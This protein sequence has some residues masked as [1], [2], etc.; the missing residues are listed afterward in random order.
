[1]R[2]VLL[3]LCTIVSISACVNLNKPEKVAECAH[4]NTCV[5][6]PI[7]GGP[8]DVRGDADASA[9]GDGQRLD[10]RDG[11]PG[12]DGPAV[13]DDAPQVG[14][15]GPAPPLDGE[16]WL[17]DGLGPVL[18]GSSDPPPLIVGDAATDLPIG[19]GDGPPADTR[20]AALPDTRD[21]NRD[22]AAGACAPGGV[23]K[24]A[25]T[26]CRA[27]LDVCD[28]EE[29]CDG[30]SADC[31]ADQ[32]VKA[33]RE[34]RAAKGDCDIAETCTGTKA[35]CPADGFKQSG[36]VCRAAAGVCDY[37][38]VCSGT[39]ATCPDDS[40]KQASAVCR[41]AVNTCDPAESCTGL[42]AT[43]PAD[44]AAYS[45]PAAPATA[46]ATPG[47][48]QASLT[49]SLVT[50]ATGY[51]IKRGTAA[52][53]PYTTIAAIAAPPFVD[54]GLDNTK[55]Y[56]YV[57]SAINTLA[58]CESTANSP[59]ASVTP[60]GICT[61]P[62]A[63]TVTAT[64]GNGQVTLSWAAVAGA[65]AYAIDRS[66]ASG[67]GYASLAQVTAP[68]ATYVDSAVTFGKTYYYRVTAKS[69]C[70]S[71][72]S[73]EVSAAPLCAPAATAPTGLAATTPNTGGI[74]VLTWN[75][76][77]GAKT[78]DRYYIMRK[79]GTGAFVKI[80][81]AVPPAVT[82]SDTTAVNGTAYSYAVT[83]FNGTCTSGNS[84]VVAATAT[85]VMD[86]PVLTATAGNKKVD[87]SWTQPANGSLTGYEVYRK[88]TGN[89]TRLTSLTGAG[90]TSYT[91]T[92]AANGT[93]YTYYV[94]AKGACDADS[95]PKTAA[96]VCTPL[97][98]PLNPK[99]T[100]G[101]ATV[102]VS[103]D[104][105]T[106][107]DHY[108]VKRGTGAGGPY[109]ALTPASPITT[110]SYTDT[111]V[112]NATTYYYVITASNGTCDSA[113][114][115]EVSAMPQVCP[116][117]GAPGTPTLAI[118]SSTQVKVDWAAATPAPSGGYNILR[119][120]TLDGTYASVGDVDGATLTFTDSTAAVNTTYYYRVEAIGALCSNRSASAEIAV[121][122][123]TPAAPTPS[124]SAATDGKITLS[125][126]VVPGATAYT[127]SRGTT[128]GS[129]APLYN[130][131][132]ITA[133][134]FTD[135]GL[136]NAT[137]YYY[138]V[139]A[140]NANGVC[141][142]PNSAEKSAMSCIIP[143]V[144]T[145]VSAT[146]T[147]NKR[148]TVAWTN[149][150]GAQS[151]GIRRSDN[152]NVRVTA[153][154]PYLDTTVTNEGTYSYVLSAASDAA[155]VCTSADSPATTAVPSCTTMS[156]SLDRYRLN[157]VS[158]LPFCFVTCWDI[159]GY[160]V[161]NQDGRTYTVN[162]S[163]T[164][165]CGSLPAKGNDGYVFNMSAGTSSTNVEVYW[166]GTAKNCP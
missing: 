24:P 50:G 94:R 105:V 45:R 20:D 36:T 142:S 163:P 117:Q 43:C 114:S 64:A 86:K 137:N 92:T 41:E 149:V 110:N 60:T 31:P 90:S 32:L 71:D 17:P 22:V 5:N 59:E 157:P 38:E 99:A 62:A 47:E 33:G 111:A 66:E 55:T 139:T 107:A 1:M 82:Y 145:G 95:D 75:A 160:G 121:T 112:V 4:T 9:S 14:D 57:I 34:C 12:L 51:S 70:D 73:A 67:T 120:T 87:L 91:D 56:Y 124:I 98:A 165:C 141:A 125:W 18:D 69:A 72:P 10:A 35:D 2:N 133:T 58:S 151:Y 30:V 123:S 28:V 13:D 161:A 63:P 79:T 136:S 156:S 108:T 148:I 25:G 102:T 77:A 80:D 65:T 39:G 135:T 84:N 166:W 109:T 130:G 49:W 88:T 8:K 138:V 101:N 128:P 118:T 155:G 81:E 68:T 21:A 44:V 143:T 153:G 23:I 11:T 144:P 3:V 37:A 85:C 100:A 48:L 103:W 19:G 7:D 52:G 42:G 61:K 134:T 93:T 40:L 78:T 29:T 159:T 162:G 154:S 74:V 129:Y 83:Y 54:T 113:N 164:T 150:T 26:V 126:S 15:D 158:A 140:S 132:N 147:G 76:V 131:A 122:C 115:T 104:A 53:G 96:P 46:T 127:I 146:R 89:Y 106:G 97:A 6:A 27:A 16:P 116:S 119:S 152:V